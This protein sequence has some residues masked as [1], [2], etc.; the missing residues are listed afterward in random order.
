MHKE[1]DSQKVAS[2]PSGEEL[3]AK[4]NALSVENNKLTAK[5][6]SLES[7]CRNLETNVDIL[8]QARER[9]HLITA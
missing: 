6:E 4:V 5:I 3:Q 2:K 9:L 1:K 7:R 8:R